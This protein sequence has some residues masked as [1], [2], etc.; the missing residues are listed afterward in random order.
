[1]NGI[2]ERVNRTLLDMVR[3]MLKTAQL[4]DKFWAEAL[5]AACHVKNRI[6][7]SAVND[8]VPEGVW[9]RNTPS[10]KHLKAYGCLAY[11]HILKQGRHKLDPRAKEC[12]LLVGY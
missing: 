11:V 2:A 4:P 3:A 7:H 5:S 12:W 8:G 10:I 1:M 6:L 9:T